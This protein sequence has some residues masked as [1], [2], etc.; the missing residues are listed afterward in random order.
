MHI[1]V[2]CFDQAIDGRRHDKNALKTL[3]KYVIPEPP[4]NGG[5]PQRKT[6]E[7]IDLDSKT[8]SREDMQ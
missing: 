2:L 1:G 3:K 8:Y 6:P 5:N 7:I 4:E